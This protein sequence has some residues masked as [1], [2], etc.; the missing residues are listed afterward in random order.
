MVYLITFC[1]GEEVRYLFTQVFKTISWDLL[2]KNLIVVKL[3]N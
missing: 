3:Q 1:E 2:D